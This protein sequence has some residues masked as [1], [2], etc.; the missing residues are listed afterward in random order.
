[1][2]HLKLKEVFGDYQLHPFD[3]Q[4]SERMILIAEK[5]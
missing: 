2:H 4:K 1:M 5:T 3:P